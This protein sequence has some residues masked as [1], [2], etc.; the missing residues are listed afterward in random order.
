MQENYLANWIQVCR[1][2]CNVNEWL[3]FMCFCF[4]RKL[5][6]YWICRHCLIRCLRRI[7]RMECWC[8][9]VTV[10]TSIEKLHRSTFFKCVT[11][12]FKFESLCYE[13]CFIS[14]L[15]GGII[16]IIFLCEFQIIIKIA[17]GNGV[18]KIL[19]GK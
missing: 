17:A 11:T 16:I 12:A 2:P 19:V 14:N 15:F 5:I 6:T 9:E 10:D 8:W 1:I 18:G 7:T 13:N 3:W 4:I